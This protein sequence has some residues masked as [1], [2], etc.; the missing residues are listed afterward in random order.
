M[1]IYQ[2][3]NVTVFQSGLFQLN[4]TVAVTDDL[5]LVVDPGYLPQEVEAIKQ[6]VDDIKGN[7][8]VYLFFTHSDFDHIVGYGAFQ[9]AITIASKEFVENPLKESQLRDVIKFDDEFYLSRPYGVEYPVIDHAIQRDG[10]KLTIGET[11]ITF[12]HAF[13][14]NN[15]GLIAVVEPLDIVIAGDYLSDIE[16]PFVYHSFAEYHKTL[17]TFKR[18]FTENRPLILITSHGS[19]TVDSDEIQ[20]RIADSEEYLQLVTNSSSEEEFNQF[21]A[22]KGYSFLTNLKLRHLDN[23]RLFKKN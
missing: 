9:E 16:F 4:T 10:E 1:I 5:V 15:D 6:Y 2:K 13:G 3:S 23:I 21:V 22:E 11:E 12:Y 7:R 18:L 8:Q 20:K 19:V 14:H 17:N